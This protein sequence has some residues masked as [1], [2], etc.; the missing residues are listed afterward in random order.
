MGQPSCAFYDPCRGCRDAGADDR[1]DGRGLLIHGGCYPDDRHTAGDV[2]VAE[3]TDQTTITHTVNSITDTVAFAW[4]MPGDK[5][6]T[7]QVS[8]E[9]GTASSPRSTI[10]IDPLRLYMPLQRRP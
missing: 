2:C 6:V 7:V 8:N 5:A 4:S 10:V 9:G 3:P 1:S